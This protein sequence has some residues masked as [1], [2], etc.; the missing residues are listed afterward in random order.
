VQ[1]F[2]N[3]YQECLAS[4]DCI[5]EVNELPCKKEGR[6]LLLPNELDDQ[7]KEYV[8]DVHKRGLPVVVAVLKVLL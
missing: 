3:L 2:K 4:I 8:K 7:L 6:P 1:R 5:E